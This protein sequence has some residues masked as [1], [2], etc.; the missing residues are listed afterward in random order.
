[1]KKA[2]VYI[3]TNIKNG[4]L[5]IGVTNDL[6]RR[7]YEHKNDLVDG[8]TK[9][10]GLHTLVYAEEHSI[11]AGAILREKQMKKW[12]RKWKIRIIEEMNPSWMDLYG[13]L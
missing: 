7:A 9:E 11:I 10:H 3:M 8:F 2:W 13:A 6:I 1:M 12:K 5:Y 4:T